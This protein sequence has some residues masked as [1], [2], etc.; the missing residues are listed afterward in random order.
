MYNF[1]FSYNYGVVNL[2][3]I[4]FIFAIS[5][6]DNWLLKDYKN[7]VTFYRLVILIIFLTLITILYIPT[8]FA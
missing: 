3:S 7:K 2:I 5:L 4:L 1:T 6:T 8:R